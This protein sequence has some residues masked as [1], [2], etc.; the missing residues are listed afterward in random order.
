MIIV[1]FVGILQSIGVDTEIQISIY[2]EDRQNYIYN[3]K[4]SIV[5]IGPQYQRDV[6][7]L[8]AVNFLDLQSIQGML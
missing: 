3:N 4:N 1:P 6:K 2:K 8:K 5:V 7:S